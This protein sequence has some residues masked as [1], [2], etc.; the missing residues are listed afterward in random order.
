MRRAEAG[1]QVD[2]FYPPTDWLD[3]NNKQIDIRK[4]AENNSIVLLV[5]HSADFSKYSLLGLLVDTSSGTYDVYID[6]VLVGSGITKNTQYDIDFSTIATSYGSATTPESLVLHKV[7]IK[8]TTSGETINLFK[9]RRTTGV[10]TA[11]SQGVLWIHFEL[12][13]DINC[14]QLI[15]QYSVCYSQN[16]Y[17]VSSKGDV[18]SVI[19]MLS[20]FYSQ[21]KSKLLKV[22]KIIN[23]ETAGYS[24]IDSF[25][26]TSIKRII[27]ENIYATNQYF[28]N[29]SDNNYLEQTIINN[30]NTTGTTTLNNNYKNNFSIKMISDIKS[31]LV[32]NMQ[33]FL[34][35]ATSLYPTKIDYSSKKLLKK[36][37]TYGTSAYPMRGLRGLKVSNEAPFTGASPQININYTGLD[38]DALRE[39]FTS[40]PYNVG[41]TIY[42]TLTE[43]PT[44]VFSGFSSSNYLLLPNSPTGITKVSY[45]IT[46]T[47]NS[48]PTSGFPY[49]FEFFRT[50]AE[51][52]SDATDLARL[53]FYYRTTSDTTTGNPYFV[54][55]ALG[56]P[57][58]IEVNIIGTNMSVVVTQNNEI[59]KEDN[60]TD[61]KIE[62]NYPNKIGGSNTWD[63]SIDLNNTDI[64]IND[65]YWFRGQAQTTKTLSLVGA[66][67]NNLA[68]VGS[69]TIDEN[70]IVSGFSASD[71]LQ[72]NNQPLN[73]YDDFELIVRAKTTK[74]G[75][76]QPLFVSGN[77]SQ[78]Y[79]QFRNTNIN[80]KVGD[81]GSLI[82]LNY[83]F[84][85]TTFYYIKVKRKGNLV[86]VSISLDG[87]TYQNEVTKEA[88][89]FTTGGTNIQIGRGGFNWG[90]NV[91]FEGEIDLEQ[92]YIRIG[93]NYLMKGYI[94]DADKNIALNKGWSLTLS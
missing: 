26:N 50:R 72:I 28:V 41:Y 29:N 84:D 62:E 86:S 65:I 18:L 20:L 23:K 7:V 32:E 33:D 48:V 47:I 39:L 1:I 3:N 91:F 8:P 58:T 34:T 16:L 11:Q 14:A 36:I 13:N 38:R 12:T 63:G 83:N 52:R 17:C 78:F 44:G 79:I 10:S 9:C 60:F 70:G 4:N 88:E 5:G 22:P 19:T 45:K 81:S 42:G 55:L 57:F 93:R 74:V 59:K 43:S 67:G 49:I 25:A 27:L 31:T 87:V 90:V 71:C 61:V 75:G 73:N 69:P 2:K 68:K 85:L 89:S 64:K 82:T 56:T 76:T 66:T 30:L 6:D 51:I 35:Q 94:T 80:V 53:R 37:G 40:L 77:T 92:T 46:A 15:S 24:P 21:L 54:N